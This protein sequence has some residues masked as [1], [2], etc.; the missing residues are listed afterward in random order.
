MQKNLIE[1]FE[2]FEVYFFPIFAP[3]ILLDNKLQLM[4]AR[5]SI[6]QKA[7][8]LHLRAGAA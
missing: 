1:I 8:N 3:H 5:P 2:V 4:F 6:V 7:F